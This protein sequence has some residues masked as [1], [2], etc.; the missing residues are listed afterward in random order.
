MYAWP[1]RSPDRVEGPSA[2]CGRPSSICGRSAR[3][4][5]AQVF[6]SGMEYSFCGMPAF[7]SGRADT[8]G[9]TVTQSEARVNSGFAIGVGLDHLREPI[10][11]LRE[12]FGFDRLSAPCPRGPACPRFL[13]QHIQILCAGAGHEAGRRAFR[14]QRF[15]YGVI[16]RQERTSPLMSAGLA[17]TAISKCWIG[18]PWKS[19]GYR[20]RR[21]ASISSRAPPCRVPKSASRRPRTAPMASAERPWPASGGALEVGHGG[22]TSRR[23]PPRGYRRRRRRAFHRLRQSAHGTG[24]T[25][26]ERA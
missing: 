19:P 2:S 24:D 20:R 15:R 21:P 10:A 1:S 12:L 16:A 14:R 8:R 13:L 4:A 3:A 5:A 11:T 9:I 23:M 22:S 6:W 7:E 26:M 18:G 17:C 25:Q